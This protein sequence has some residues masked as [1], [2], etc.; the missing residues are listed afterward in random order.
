MTDKLWTKDP[1]I[2]PPWWAGHS[3]PSIN[4]RR[5]ESA[6]DWLS[7]CDICR[8]RMVVVDRQG[9]RTIHISTETI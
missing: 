7:E 3:R 1:A 9:V 6:V 4:T 2:N 5:Q 8:L